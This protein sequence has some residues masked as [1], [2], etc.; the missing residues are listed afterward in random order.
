MK[1]RLSVTAWD[2]S[3]KAGRRV[4]PGSGGNFVGVGYDAGTNGQGAVVR[5]R[6][7]GNL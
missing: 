4:R 3:K 6:I 1:N 2:F 7:H 5:G